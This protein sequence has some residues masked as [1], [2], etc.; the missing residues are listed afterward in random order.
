MQT[1]IYN[2]KDPNRDRRIEQ[3][4]GIIMLI[5]PWQLE[6]L[7]EEEKLKEAEEKR[8]RELEEV[9]KG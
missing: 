3:G 2:Y 7:K 6:K 9:G 4:T 1:I 5:P 8:R